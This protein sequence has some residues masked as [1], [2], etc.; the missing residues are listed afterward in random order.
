AL[1]KVGMNELERKR[2]ENMKKRAELFL[3]YR[4]KAVKVLAGKGV[5]PTTAKRI[6]G[7]YHKDEES[8]FRDILESEKIFAKTKKYWKI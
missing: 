3:Y 2:Y 6:L 8:L 4:A 5:G 7:K 1:R